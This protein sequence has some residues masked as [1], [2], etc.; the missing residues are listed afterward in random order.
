[1]SVVNLKSVD[2]LE[3][4]I[5]TNIVKLGTGAE[6]IAYLSLNDN[7]VYKVLTDF[8]YEDKV[9]DIITSSD[10]DL[11]YFLLPEDL[12]V[13][14][15]HLI[16]YKT[17]YISKNLFDKRKYNIKDINFDNL[18]IAYKNILKEVKLLSSNKIKTCDITFNLLF[19]G[20]DLYV[21]DTCGYRKVNK[22]INEI[23]RCNKLYLS[24]AIKDILSIYMRKDLSL[25]K[26]NKLVYI[27]DIE[28]QLNEIKNSIK[29]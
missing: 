3:K 16:A 1:M 7:C 8:E 24:E 15:N 4:I 6:G 20:K 14:D 22:D 21:I 19:D 18:I 11:K 5:G 13:C 29:R 23:Y 27:Q 9:D 26:Y 12:Y 10:I 2:E 17:K 25:D 28:E